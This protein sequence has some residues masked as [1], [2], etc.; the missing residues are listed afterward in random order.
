MFKKIGISEI[1]SIFIW[2]VTPA[3]SFWLLETLTHSVSED[4]ELPIIALNLA[5]YYLLYGLILVLSKRSFI[6]LS[7]G[8]LL[9]MIVG[10]VDYYVIQF[11]SVPLYPWDIFSVGT[12]MSVSDNYSYSLDKEAMMIVAGFIL[13]ILVGLFTRWRLPMKHRQYHLFSV[14]GVLTV[15]AL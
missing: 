13:L 2:L 3:V 15:W 4:M 14:L 9:V 8:S 6:S 1:P 7:L 11:R 12:A 5:F 10:L